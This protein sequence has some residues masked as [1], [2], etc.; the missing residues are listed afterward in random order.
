MELIKNHINNSMLKILYPA[1]LP[2]TYTAPGC[3]LRYMQVQVP[4]LT[5]YSIPQITEEQEE[6]WD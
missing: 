5:S 4:V 2:G 6:D 1:S 3:E